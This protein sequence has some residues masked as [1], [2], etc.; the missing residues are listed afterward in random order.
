MQVSEYSSIITEQLSSMGLPG[1][2]IAILLVAVI[3][4]WR[5]L[6]Q[7]RSRCEDLVDLM[8]EQSRETALMIERITGR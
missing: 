5:A 1:M 6:R 8:M 7:E 3:A 4:L 2:V